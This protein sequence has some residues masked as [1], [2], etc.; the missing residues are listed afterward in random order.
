MTKENNNATGR[1]ML[2]AE[3]LAKREGQV[4]L[5]VDTYEIPV[6]KHMF[7]RTGPRPGDL[8]RQ[9]DE[10]GDLLKARNEDKAINVKLS[11]AQ[12]S[13]SILESW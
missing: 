2:S 4:D 3:M 8:F 11:K 1:W 10:N 6:T 12:E 9:A 7:S 5:M 13:R